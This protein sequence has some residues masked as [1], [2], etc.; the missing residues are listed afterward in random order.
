M[1]VVEKCG[2]EKKEPILEVPVYTLFRA[3]MHG[4]NPGRGFGWGYFFRGNNEA[5]VCIG[6]PDNGFGYNSV[7]EFSEYYKV[8][9]VYPNA[10]I[11]LNG[12]GK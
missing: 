7:K 5:I 8:V 10:K 1:N 3:E 11:C 4:Y 12:V 9:E 6:G 2:V